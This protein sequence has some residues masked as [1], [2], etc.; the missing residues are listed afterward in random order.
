MASEKDNMGAFKDV[1]KEVRLMI[2]DKLTR[3][4]VE[5]WN[6]RNYN[7]T[8]VPEEV[9]FDKSKK[10]LESQRSESEESE[11][12]P[13]GPQDNGKH[14]EVGNLAIARTCRALHKDVS[15]SLYTLDT[16]CIGIRRHRNSHVP[17]WVWQISSQ[18]RGRICIANPEVEIPSMVLNLPYHKFKGI[19]FVVDAPSM[20][21][22]G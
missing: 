21:D 8:K 16:I 5:E 7:Y 20:G 1:P 13:P 10:D 9:I 14:Q 3:V 2:W 6:A 19:H 22:P 12:Y 4:T 15:I 17:H 11:R 18:L